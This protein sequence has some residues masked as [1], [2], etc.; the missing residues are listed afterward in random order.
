MHAYER[1]PPGYRAALQQPGPSFAYPAGPPR[2]PAR[3]A[4]RTPP[5]S[6]RSSED[7]F[8]ANYLDNLRSDLTQN[9]K[10][11]IN[12]LTDMAADNRQFAPAVVDALRVH[13]L[14]CRNSI[15]LCALYLCDSIAKNV[16]APYPDLFAKDIDTMFMEIW[17]NVPENRASLAR[18][19]GTW[20]GVFPPHLIRHLIAQTE[21]SGPAAPL[22]DAGRGAA[23]PRRPAVEPPATDPRRA[24]GPPVER[25]RTPPLSGGAPPPGPPPAPSMPAP[26]PPFQPPLRGDNFAPPPRG[27]SFGSPPVAMP[28][29]AH[30][31]S[32]PFDM[33][34]SSRPGLPPPPSQQRP[35]AM[36]M[37]PP[38]PQGQQQQHLPYGFPPQ[39]NMTAAPPP[40]QQQQPPQ[41]M[42]PPPPL[43]Q[44][45]PHGMGAPPPLQQQRQP[46][47]G[48]GAPPPLQQRQ[49][50]Q[51][52]GAQPPLQQQQRQPQPPAPPATA[53]LL[54]QLLSG[55]LLSVLPNLTAPPSGS[56]GT[57]PPVQPPKRLTFD[58]PAFQEAVPGAVEEL[59]ASSQELRGKHLDW[60]FARKKRQ[61]ASHTAS[62][63]WY[64]PS[65]LWVTGCQKEPN[66]ATPIF[67]TNDDMEAPVVQAVSVPA[68][69]AQTT[70]AISGEKFEEF[71]DEG[72][73]EWR[74]RDAQKLSGAEAR[75]YHVPEGSIV[76]VSCLATA[77]VLDSAR[78][79]VV[80]EDVAEAEAELAGV[81]DDAAE[82]GKRKSAGE[83][84]GS[85]GKKLKMEPS[86]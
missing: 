6:M 66:D 53:D 60:K 3:P 32:P 40:P 25:V 44:R 62:R 12:F 67:F 82:A 5:G 46:P 63:P 86:A 1:A 4:G 47:H 84:G 20:E 75:R 15:K 19:L 23:D 27:D 76:L 33:D 54:N 2:L 29:R 57:P 8:F 45:Q 55:G 13:I 17:R 48:M 70:C 83:G 74:Y 14:E 72:R 69:D 31:R 21:R 73:Q 11:V 65:A 43:Q 49:P 58:S 64:L 80:A 34:G 42:R 50:P 9:S 36:P 71:F 51:G 35:M 22:R 61:R 16:G 81:T 85:E 41:G 37:M 52:M 38:P 56:N 7:L 10:P 30:M 59:L 18:L 28:P 78:G 68:D 39:P 26:P 77:T 24:R 79:A